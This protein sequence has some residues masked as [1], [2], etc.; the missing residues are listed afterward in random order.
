MG[1]FNWR[2]RQQFRELS[3]AREIAEI[4]IRNGLGVMV[5][6]LEFGRFIPSGWRRRAERADEELAR[7]SIPERVRHTLEDLGPTYIKMGQLLSGRGDLLP[8]GYVQEF[9]KLLDQA[10]PFPYEE[11]VKQIESEFGEPPEKIFAHF[12]PAPIAAASIGQVHRAVLSNGDRVV[13]KVQRPGIEKTVQSDLDLLARQARFLERRSETLRN[14]SLVEN[15]EELGY[16]LKKELDYRAEAQNIDR[17]RRSYAKSPSIRMPLVYWE[18]TTKRVIVMDDITGIPFTDLDRM[19]EEGYDLPAIAQVVCDFY[20]RQIFEDGFFHADPHPANLMVS[21]QQVAVLDFGM[22]AFISQRMR[23][24]LSD[25]FVTVF[26]M[27]T[28]QMVTIIV[29]MGLTTRATNL[30][31]LERDINRMLL[32][33]MGLPL[34]QIPVAQVMSE[35]LAISFN[36]HVRLPTDVAMLIRAIIILEGLGRKLDPNFDI[37]GTLEPYVRKLVQSKLSVK[38]IGL[39]AMRTATSLNTLAQRLP[40]RLD[41][42]WDQIDEGN[43][44]IGVNVREI[45]YILGRADKIVNRVVFSVIVAALILGSAL[46][47]RLGDAAADA[48]FQIPWLGLSI[49]FAQVGFIFAGVCGA[50]LLWSIIRSRGL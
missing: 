21:G 9:T 39:A 35:T 25:L 16:A 2:I 41:E 28:E 5:D 18:Y 13:V 19:R 42:L 24:D 10:P 43:L 37:V 33:Y 30:R 45:S 32:Q 50:W 31:E 20:M 47:L 40:I 17:F 34:D 48:L 3:R 38:R 15:L 26:T 27:N 12:D 36:H 6:Q 14:Y 44:T 22:V 11:V 49:P 29:R 7:M 46:V 4:L 23:E 1:I 8:E